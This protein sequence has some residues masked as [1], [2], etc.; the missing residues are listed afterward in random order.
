[1]LLLTFLSLRSDDE[2][3]QAVRRFLQWFLAPKEVVDSEGGLGETC[4]YF[5]W[6]EARCVV[7]YPSG[8]D[9]FEL[10]GPVRLSGNLEHKTN[11]EEVNLH[12]KASKCLGPD[13]TRTTPASPETVSPA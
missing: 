11:S 9:I 5:H 6:V 13:E 2:M 8:V 4:C 12:S 3:N 1:M 10:E 7:R